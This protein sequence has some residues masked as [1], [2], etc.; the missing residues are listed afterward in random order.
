MK[1]GRFGK[2]PSL[3]FNVIPAP[4]NNAPRFQNPRNDALLLENDMNGLSPFDFD[5]IM[6]HP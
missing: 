4:K 2:R 6:R 3:F 5:K 1:G